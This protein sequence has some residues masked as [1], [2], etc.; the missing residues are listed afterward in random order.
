M[1]AERWNSAGIQEMVAIA[2]GGIS[3]RKLNLFTNWCCEVLRPYM[4]DRRSIAAVRF[5]DRHVDDRHEHADEQQALSVEA[6]AAV[7][8]L[9]IWLRAHLRRG[10]T[11]TP[12]VR[13]RRL[14][15]STS[16]KQPVAKRRHLVEL[17][18][19][20]LCLRLGK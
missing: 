7:A 4:K 15:G 3:S 11:S 14:S 16:R 20:S 5:A 13:V 6:R 9:T 17:Q 18:V 1:S 2:P 12:R 19:H 10:A 8:D